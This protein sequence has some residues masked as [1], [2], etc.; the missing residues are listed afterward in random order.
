MFI[1]FLIQ[2]DSLNTRSRQSFLL[3]TNQNAHLITHVHKGLQGITRVY[4]GLQWVARVWFSG[5][6]KS[7]QRL[8]GDYKGNTYSLRHRKCGVRGFIHELF[9]SKTRTSEVQASEGF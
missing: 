1:N 5:G 2:K 7:I 4:K 9:V 8:T 6:Y 3:L